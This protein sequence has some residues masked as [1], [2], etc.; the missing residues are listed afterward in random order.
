MANRYELAYIYARVCGAAARTWNASRIAELAHGGKAGDAW[1]AVFNEAPPSLPANVLVDEAERKAIRS[2][3]SEYQELLNHLSGEEPFFEALRRKAEFA[4]V[5]RV[6]L[7]VHTNEPKCPESDDPSLKPGFY[8]AAYPDIAKMFAGGHYSWI[9]KEDADSFAATE[10]RLDIQYYQEL[11]QALQT[12]KPV[13][14]GAVEELVG[15]DIELQN[16]L[17]A[18]RLSRYYGM[19]AEKI[20][21]LLV[22]IEGRD[23]ISA[24]LAC[25]DKRPDKRDE[26]SGWKYEFL[27]GGDEQESGWLLDVRNVELE[28]RR[29]IYRRLKKALHLH[30][31]SYTPLYCYFKLKEFETVTVLSLFEGIS[32]GAPVEE[33]TRLAPSSGG[34]V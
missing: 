15:L 16:V 5:K 25:V 26:W 13:R 28:A 11:W 23:F 8:A 7:A 19:N 21:P 1:R 27:I 20:K 30:P 34:A 32:L 3:F 31:F 18:L 4:R 29:Y 6:I 22:D 24:A 10:N 17:W 12:I 33:I 2:A 9:K 14:R